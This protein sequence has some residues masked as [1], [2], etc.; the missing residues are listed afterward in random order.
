MEHKGSDFVIMMS[1]Y[2]LV[3]ALTAICS[4]SALQLANSI[5]APPCTHVSKITDG[6]NADWI[7]KAIISST[8]GQSSV[9]SLRTNT[10]VDM[11]PFCCQTDTTY[12]FDTELAK[13]NFTYDGEVTSRGDVYQ[14]HGVRSRWFPV[15]ILAMPKLAISDHVDDLSFSSCC[16]VDS[17]PE[18]DF[19]AQIMKNLQ[20]MAKNMD[21]DAWM[22]APNNGS[23][24]I[25]LGSLQ[26]R[27]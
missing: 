11:L 27:P 5:V 1:S 20:E 10:T 6:F 13:G 18:T 14:F 21:A 16:I 2:S 22:Y 19:A 24:E 26:V 3:N 9:H 12:M 7:W 17:I 25:T 4:L 15:F 23:D 8:G